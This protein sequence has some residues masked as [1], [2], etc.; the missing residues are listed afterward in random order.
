MILT[1]HQP[2]YL[3]WLGLFHKIALADRF[4]F[5]D[6]VQ[7][8]PK[9]WNNRN[10]I[11]FNNGTANWLTVPVF[12]KSY[13]DHSYLE[14]KINNSIPWQRKHW[15]SIELNYSKAPYFYLY[16]KELSKFYEVHWKYLCDLNYKMLLFFLDILNISIPVVRMKD[17]SFRGKKSDLVIDMCR[18][19]EADIYIFGEQGKNYADIEAFIKA[20]IL[21]VFQKYQH[22][23]YPQ[24]H[25]NFIS[26]LSIVDLLFNCGPKSLKML[27]SNNLCKDDIDL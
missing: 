13:L 4:C 3:P 22:P 10:K 19:L 6:K 18:Q 15:R 27:M 2:V 9:D 21:P 23:V 11:K 20:G 1:A 26:H 5:F 14:I 8:Q 16:A 24:L 17:Y 7:Y 25:E 12:R